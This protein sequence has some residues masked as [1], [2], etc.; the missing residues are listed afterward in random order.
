MLNISEHTPLLQSDPP[1]PL[2]RETIDDNGGLARS[3]EQIPSTQMFRQ[4]L[5]I[6]IGY[7]IPVFAYVSSYPPDILPTPPVTAHK[8][9]SIPFSLRPSYA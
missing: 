1:A 3:S 9:L 8:S 7:S 6:L 4:E 5:R 2:V